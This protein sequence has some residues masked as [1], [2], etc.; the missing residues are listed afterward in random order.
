[1]ERSTMLCSR[2]NQLFRLGHGFN[3]ELLVYQAGYNMLGIRET[4]REIVVLLFRICLQGPPQQED[5]MVFLGKIWEII[6]Q[7]IGLGENL[8][9]NPIFN[10][11]KHGFL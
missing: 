3:S 8:Q 1:M 6:Y 11:K 2:V 4:K 9:E 10:G 5:P 7:W